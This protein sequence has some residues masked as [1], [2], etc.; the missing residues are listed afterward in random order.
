M[1]L[2]PLGAARTVAARPNI[3]PRPLQRQ[4]TRVEQLQKLLTLFAQ[5]ARYALHQR[6]RRRFKRLHT[7]TCIGLRQCRA[8][9]EL[10]T[11]MV[12]VAGMRIEPLLQHSQARRS[13]Q[14]PIDHHQHLLPAT[15]ALA[16]LIR[17]LTPDHRIE[18][19]S[20]QKLQ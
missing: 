10:A 19:P 4:A 12:V 18:Y 11:Q 13:R 1:Q 17:L 8:A 2:Q 9:D 20:R 3:K 5:L 6:L 14:L 15:K 7:P 16:V